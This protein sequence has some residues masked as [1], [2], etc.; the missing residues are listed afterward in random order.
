MELTQIRAGEYPCVGNAGN[1]QTQHWVC[2]PKS[3][4]LYKCINTTHLIIS[5]YACPANHL[6]TS[7]HLIQGSWTW[8]FWGHRAKHL[9]DQEPP[10]IVQNE[11]KPPLP[12]PCPLADT[13]VGVLKKATANIQIQVR[14]AAPLKFVIPTG[15]NSD[16]QRVFQSAMGLSSPDDDDEDHSSQSQSVEA[17]KK[18]QRFTKHHLCHSFLPAF[19]AND[20]AMSFRMHARLCRVRSV[21]LALVVA[22]PTWACFQWWMGWTNV[23]WFLLFCSVLHCVILC[24]EY[25]VLVLYLSWMPGHFLYCIKHKQNTLSKS[26]WYCLLLCLRPYCMHSLDIVLWIAM[27]YCTSSCFRECTATHL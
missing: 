23:S 9:V 15:Q 8:M 17:R 1:K 2:K 3:K 12:I 14:N 27:A 25:V 4:S 26:V 5:L 21:S 22:I 11:L 7:T 18:W 6:Y 10:T 19:K 20:I 16:A 13:S 24:W